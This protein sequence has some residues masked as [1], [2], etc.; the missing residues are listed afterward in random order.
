MHLK[1]L[2]VEKHKNLLYTAEILLV[3]LIFSWKF[4]IPTPFQSPSPAPGL[5]LKNKD[6][7]VL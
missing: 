5:V 2:A 7:L 6:S 1:I 3:L 4:V